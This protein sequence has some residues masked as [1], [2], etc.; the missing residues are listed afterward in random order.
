MYI[1]ILWYCTTHILG[2]TGT[3]QT[4]WCLQ[5]PI[6]RN[7]SRC[8]PFLKGP[9]VYHYI[10]II[11]GH[12]EFSKSMT[13]IILYHHHHYNAQGGDVEVYI[14]QKMGGG[15]EVNIMKPLSLAQSLTAWLSTT[16]PAK[17]WSLIKRFPVS[18]SAGLLL[19][20]WVGWPSLWPAG[21]PR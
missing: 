8:A 16:W 3:S 14:R 2:F 13:V 6:W 18:P 20:S 4:C 7:F 19:W 5:R 21:Q 10:I 9:A 15:N 17:A 12:A 1:I 11:M